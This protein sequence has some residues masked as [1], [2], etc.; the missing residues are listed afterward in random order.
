MDNDIL[1][2]AQLIS[3]NSQYHFRLKKKLQSLP[4]IYYYIRAWDTHCNSQE[5]TPLTRH[6]HRMEKFACHSSH[7][8]R[9]CL[10]KKFFIT[11]FKQKKRATYQDIILSTV[12]QQFVIDG[13][14]PDTPARIFWR[15]TCAIHQAKLTT[16]L[17]YK[18]AIQSF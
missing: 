15:E 6:A 16:L 7:L 5:E 1:R 18:R 2:L 12:V 9:V 4:L 10:N 8:F 13:A 3:I 14:Y 17:S 11:N